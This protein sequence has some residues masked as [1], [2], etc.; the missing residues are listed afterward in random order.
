MNKYKRYRERLKT[1][2]ERWEHV[3][4][5]TAIRNK[6][7]RDEWP[8]KI[9]STKKKY[10]EENREALSKRDREYNKML[11]DQSNRCY[12]CGEMEART[13]QGKL[14]NLAVD[15]CHRTGR[16]RKLLC[17]RCNVV[18]GFVKE[19]PSLLTKL[20]TYVEAV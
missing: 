18:I 15:H 12:V 17:W 2:P 7:H 3:R 8:E 4:K 11:T 9:K 13:I 1:D 6:R 19:N 14:L 5:I 10:R 16:V 20:A